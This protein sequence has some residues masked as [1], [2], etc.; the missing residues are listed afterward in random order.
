MSLQDTSA[1]RVDLAT[2]LIASALLLIGLVMVTSAS[3]ATAAQEGSGNALSYLLGQLLPVAAGLVAGS[4]VLFIPTSTWERYSLHI[5]VACVVGLLLVLVPGVGT[6]VNGSR[7]WIRVAGIGV[8][9]SEFARLGVMLWVASYAVRQEQVLRTRWS[10][11]LRP[12]G[13]VAIPALL[14]FAE[15]DLG[16]ATVLLI[17]AFVLLFVAGARLGPVLS[18]A[19]GM[20]ALVGL[21]IWLSPYRMARVTS[22]LNPWEDPFASG[23]QLTQSLIAIG[24]GQ[25]LGVGLGDSVQKMFY[26]PEAHTDFLFA[27]LAEEF[28][29]LGVVVVIALFLALT[30]R[31]MQIARQAAEAGYQFQSYVA[32]GFGIWIGVQALLNIGV[33]M[34]VLPTKGLT[35][36]LLS[37][38]R[39]SL[40]VTLLW[41]AL[42]M[43]VH[44]EALGGLRVA[45]GAARRRSSRPAEPLEA[46]A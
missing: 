37:Y 22:F 39:S 33:N 28:G 25:W 7:R 10:G 44:H 6:V 32:A 35:L 46:S 8:Q 14:I 4:I 43:R 13:L 27:V 34:G 26:L 9:V 5:F 2:L 15:P 21:A 11:L 1:P 36:P 3:S 38:G 17:S 42:V 19:G 23:F 45:A 18:V 40:F 12:L 30:W 41:L 16:G 31:V 24:R 29:F 20:A